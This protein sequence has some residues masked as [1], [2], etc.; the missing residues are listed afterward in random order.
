MPIFSTWS[1]AVAQARGVDH[2]QRHAFDLDGLADHVA[3]GAGDRRDDRQ[4]GAGQR[5]EQRALAGVGLAGDHHLDAFAQQRAL[6]RALH[7]PRQRLP[8]AA[9]AGPARRPSAGSRFPLPG[10]SSVAST[11]MRRWISASRS[12]WISRENSPDSE[13]LALR[14]AASVLASIRSAMASACARSILSLR[15]ARW[16]NSPGCGHAQA[17]RRRRPPGSAPAAAAAPPARRGPAAPARLRRCR[18]GAPGKWIARPWSMALP[19]AAR[20]GR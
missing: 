4:L 7:H 6:A 11:S 10:K 16:V 18:N 2:M 20:N 5:I 3:R 1:C 17:D 12:A 15:K 19:S 14:A 9:R 8:A 13:R